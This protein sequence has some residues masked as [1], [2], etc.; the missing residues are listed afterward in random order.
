[1]HGVSQ[2]A[3]Y[4]ESWPN[5][6]SAWASRSRFDILVN[7][8]GEVHSLL[9]CSTGTL[10]VPV[11]RLASGKILNEQNIK[12]RTGPAL[13]IFSL[14]R[15]EHIQCSYC[16]L[17]LWRVVRGSKLMHLDHLIHGLFIT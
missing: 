11:T 13:Y 8:Y 14:L 1:M 6:S 9:I 3:K 4:L 12:R 17:S 15:Y 5:T 10:G 16:S 2:E 7:R